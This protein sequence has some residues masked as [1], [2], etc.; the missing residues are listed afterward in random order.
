MVLTLQKVATSSSN[1]WESQPT[2][3]GNEHELPGAMAS[4]GHDDDFLGIFHEIPLDLM[5]L[6]GISWGSMGFHRIS[7]G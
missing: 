6:N 1:L 3:W 2:P 4:N 5:R 7:S